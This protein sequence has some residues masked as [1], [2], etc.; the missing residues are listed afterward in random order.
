MRDKKPTATAD[1]AA[2]TLDAADQQPV[3]L[4]LQAKAALAALLAL[5]D[6]RFTASAERLEHYRA[7]RSAL[8]EAL[9][10]F[11]AVTGQRTIAT[12]GSDA[13]LASGDL[14]NAMLCVVAAHSGDMVAGLL[15][16]IPARPDLRAEL[17]SYGPTHADGCD[18][19]EAGQR[20]LI[21]AAAAVMA[22]DDPGAGAP[23]SAP[24]TE[25][26]PDV[27]SLPVSARLELTMGATGAAVSV[28][29][30][31]EMA[32]IPADQVL[33]D[34]G[35]VRAAVFQAVR[36]LAATIARDLEE[37]AARSGEVK[38]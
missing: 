23:P 31:S 20:R 18:D 11:A 6:H 36:R 16:D 5:P 10:R 2:R 4:A 32:E 27:V 14:G 1:A 15:D 29:A 25:A 9:R 26:M 38:P 30:Y 33:A 28:A 34:P 8:I 35:S 22:G 7:G 37:L 17:R 21:A 3:D 12:T 24:P 13:L 19:G